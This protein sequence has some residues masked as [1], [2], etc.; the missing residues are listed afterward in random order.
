MTAED[1]E[2]IAYALRTNTTIAE[3]DIGIERDSYFIIDGNDIG[4]AG[5]IAVAEALKLNT[6]LTTVNLGNRRISYSFTRH[7]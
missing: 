5:V 7:H 2:A 4:D 1:A 3:L 6:K